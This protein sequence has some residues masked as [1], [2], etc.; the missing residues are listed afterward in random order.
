MT[1]NNVLL[2]VRSGCCEG[3]NPVRAQSQAPTRI[4]ARVVALACRIG[5]IA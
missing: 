3:I 1:T 2:S 4:V 5:T